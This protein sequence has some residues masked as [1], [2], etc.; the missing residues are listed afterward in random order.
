MWLK[1]EIV[2]LNV[3][4]LDPNKTGGRYVKP[5]DWNAL[6]V[7]P[8]VLLIGTRNDY[9]VAIGSSQGAVN[10]Q[11]KTFTEPPAWLDARP[12]LW[13]EDGKRTKVAMFCTGGIRCEKFTA[14]L[15][16]AVSTRST[17]WRVASSST[18]KKRCPSTALGTAIASCST[19][20]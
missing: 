15:K 8:N 20:G 16:C 3:P 2:T 1:K 10:P 4:G 17:T 18:W 13:G 19:S 9:E 12:E 11:I 5:A 6:L 14:L 7:N